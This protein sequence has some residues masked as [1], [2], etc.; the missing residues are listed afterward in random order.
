[1]G[2][3]FPATPSAA[4]AHDGGPVRGLMAKPGAADAHDAGLIFSAKPTAVVAYDVG[5]SPGFSLQSA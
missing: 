3:Q 1:M 2:Q 5:S 4:D